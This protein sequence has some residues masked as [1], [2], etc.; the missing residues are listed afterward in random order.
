M[1]P[2][3]LVFVPL[4]PSVRPIA[5][6]PPLAPLKVR[7]LRSLSLLSRSPVSAIWPVPRLKVTASS[8]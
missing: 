1:L 5:T 4:P 7:S 6:A 3:L 8:R 2:R